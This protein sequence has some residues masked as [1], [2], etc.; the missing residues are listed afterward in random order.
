MAVLPMGF[1]P[2]AAIGQALTWC[3]VDVDP[4]ELQ[5]CVIVTYIDNILVLGPTPA[6]VQRLTALIIKRAISVGAQFSEG[7]GRDEARVAAE[8]ARPEHQPT[9]T[10]DFLGMRYDLRDKSVRQS[11]KTATKVDSIL[12]FLASAPESITCTA[13]EFAAMFG[14]AL[15]ASS[16]CATREHISDYRPAFQYFRKL[17]STQAVSAGSSWSRSITVSGQALGSLRSWFADLHTNPPTSI[18]KPQAPLNPDVIFVDASAEGWGAVHLRDGSVHVVAGSWTPADHASHN[19]SSSVSAEPLAISRALARCIVPLS[20]EGVI[21]YTDHMPAVSA[22]S[23]PCAKGYAYWRLQQFLLHFP[24]PVEIR[25]IPGTKN[26][27][28]AS[29]RGDSSCGKAWHAVYAEALAHHTTAVHATDNGDHGEAGERHEW[30][31]TARNPERVL[32]QCDGR[33]VHR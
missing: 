23:S 2:S 11:S 29:S 9:Q 17:A 18:T 7:T 31:C 14:L 33:F 27:A 30:T 12:A 10:F 13:R 5:G 6:A 22:C 19:L 26:P 20:S 1:R 8:I 32:S 21:V 3:I 28:D 4:L 16:S 25:W 15:F 24:T